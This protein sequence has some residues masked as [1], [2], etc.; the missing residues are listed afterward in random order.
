M[1]INGMVNDPVPLSPED[2]SIVLDRLERLVQKVIAAKMPEEKV[3]RAI[4]NL[5]DGTIRDV[6]I[7]IAASPYRAHP[8]VLPQHDDRTITHLAEWQRKLRR[9]GGSPDIQA[10]HLDALERFELN[11]QASDRS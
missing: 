4:G 10:L 2:H 5:V 7:S 1:R 8:S 6:T 3:L 11:V 9:S